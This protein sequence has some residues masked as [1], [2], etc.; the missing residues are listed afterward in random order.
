MKK[1]L[2]LSLVLLMVLTVA[3][4]GR[5]LRQQGCHRGVRPETRR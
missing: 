2:T 3:F 4:T 5:G 1:A